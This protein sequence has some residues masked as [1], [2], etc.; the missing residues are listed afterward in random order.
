MIL[1]RVSEF[2]LVILGQ[3]GAGKTCAALLFQSHIS[4]FSAYVT[5]THWADMHRRGKLAES[6]RQANDFK[7]E[8][9]L[10]DKWNRANCCI[11]DD[12]GTREKASDHRYEVLL[13]SINK[14]EGRPLVVISN[15]E[16]LE[17]IC[18]LYD[19]RIASRLNGGTVVTVA[20]DQRQGAR[21]E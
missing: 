3:A 15:A 10:W 9:W 20:G 6:D 21:V 5:E 11:I 14:R 2:P 8:R 1:N 17:M 16:N 18:N 4:D 13:N 19:E 12:V 7:T